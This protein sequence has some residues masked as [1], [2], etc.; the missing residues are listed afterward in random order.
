MGSCLGNITMK[1]LT[2]VTL[3]ITFISLLLSTEENNE[4]F[5]NK[6]IGAPKN[7]SDEQEEIDLFDENPEFWEI[8]CDDETDC[9]SDWHCSDLP[10]IKPNICYA[11]AYLPSYYRDLAQPDVEKV[12]EFK[13]NQINCSSS[14]PDEERCDCVEGYECKNDTCRRGPEFASGGVNVTTVSAVGGIKKLKISTSLISDQYVNACI[15]Y[16]RRKQI[17][18]QPRC[19]QPKRPRFRRKR[20]FCDFKW[21]QQKFPDNKRVSQVVGLGDSR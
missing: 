13:I 21:F 6:C 7:K 5:I 20:C 18:Y 14:L 15:C 12:V 19:Y 16:E 1:S 9:P 11:P 4:D 3:L 8:E 2:L 10:D 17:C